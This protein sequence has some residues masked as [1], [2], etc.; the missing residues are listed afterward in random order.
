MTQSVEQQIR[1]R[2]RGRCEYCHLPE[3]ISK[4]AFSIDHV[5]AKQHGGRSELS[6]LALA[7]GFCNRHKGPNISGLDPQTRK[8]CA[9]FNP[10]RDKWNTHFRWRAAHLNGKTAIG[11]TTVAVLAMNHPQQL[12]IRQSLIDEGMDLG[13]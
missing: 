7:C 8:L 4:L 12:L 1:R 5:I 3:S 9:L 6:N 11:R 2:S 10:R 13:Q